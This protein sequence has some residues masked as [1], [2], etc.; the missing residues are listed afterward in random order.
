MWTG[1]HHR[2]VQELHAKYGPV[3]RIA[4]NNLSYINPQAWKDIYAHKKTRE[5]EMI[6]DPEFYVRNPDAPTIV[7]GNHEEHA[8]YRRL[9]SPGFSARSLREQE[10][11]IQGYVDM[12]I[13]GLARACEHGE[14]P[15]DMVQWFNWVTFDIIGDLAFGEPFGCLADGAT[16]WLLKLNQIEEAQM[17]FRIIQHIPLLGRYARQIVNT[18]LPSDAVKGSE[19]HRKLT[20]EKVTRRVNNNASRPDFMEHILRQPPGKGFTMGEMLSNSATLIQAGSETTATLLSGALHLLVNH[21]DKMQKLVDELTT[22]FASD[23]MMTIEN[24]D[25]L[26]Y[27]AA[28]LEESL[29]LYSPAVPGFPRQVPKGGAMIDGDYVPGGTS[30]AVNHYAA[31]HSPLNFSRPNE[32]IP[33]RFIDTA[34]FPD[35][36]RD[37]LQPFSVGPRNCIGKSLAY[38][39]G[40]LILGRAVWKF[41]MRLSEKSHGWMSDQKGYVTW[42]RP[43]MEVYVKMRHG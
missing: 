6:K 22:S 21:P 31:Y 37:V 40:R 28:V 10:P 16:D 20:Q 24:T 7:N 34:A 38:A 17:H 1:Y 19:G 29:R 8:R 14:T 25:R 42:M 3:V 2:A 18:M 35:D 23:D 27:L 15:V 11:L 26:P 33:E 9:Y 13:N 30:V 12:F 39:E 36:R 4:P 5:Q 43:E 32:F 41:D